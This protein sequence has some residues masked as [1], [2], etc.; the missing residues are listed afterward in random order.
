TRT[1]KV[2]RGFVADKYKVLIDALYEGR[3]VQHIETQV[4]F[5]DGR[6]GMVAADLRIVDAK[7]FPAA[8]RK[9]A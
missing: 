7:T 9:A 2:R 8:T 3:E 1:R 5:E 4:K 6:T